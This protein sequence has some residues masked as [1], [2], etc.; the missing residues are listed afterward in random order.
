MLMGLLALALV[1]L[2]QFGQNPAGFGLQGLFDVTLTG[3]HGRADAQPPVVNAQTQCG[4]RGTAQQV[5]HHCGAQHH[6][7]RRLWMSESVGPR[8][9]HG[10][11]QAWGA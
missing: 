9:G 7:M 1:A 8:R 10:D 3:T 6:P 5:C 11:D 4:A 2:Q